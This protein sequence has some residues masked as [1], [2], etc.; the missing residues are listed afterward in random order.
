MNKAD[1]EIADKHM[2]EIRRLL[3]AAGATYRVAEHYV[4]WAGPKVFESVT[5]WLGTTTHATA[6]LVPI[7]CGS[8]LEPDQIVVEHLG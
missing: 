2:R 8:W 5:R 6:E 7:K 1:R 3:R 4:V